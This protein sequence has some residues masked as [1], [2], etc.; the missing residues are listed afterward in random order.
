MDLIKT[1]FIEHG[2]EFVMF[3]F[4]GVATWIGTIYR[5]YINTKQKKEI[6][7]ATVKYVEQI[8]TNLLSEEKLKKA[9]EKALEWLKEC[10]LKISDTE[11]EILIESTVNS[12]KN[13]KSIS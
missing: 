7:E 6:V 10:N 4:T 5:K 3:I 1:I 2:Y 13:G 11:L 9:K 8:G 12:F